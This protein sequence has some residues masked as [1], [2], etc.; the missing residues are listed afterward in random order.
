[1]KSKGCLLKGVMIGA[2]RRDA[3]PVFRYSG[4]TM[5]MF[6]PE[7]R[8]ADPTENGQ[9]E[10]LGRAKRVEN[11]S[12]VRAIEK[13]SGR[14]YGG[15]AENVDLRKSR[16][17]IDQDTYRYSSLASVSSAYRASASEKRDCGR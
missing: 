2:R 15:N 8:D 4:N 3:G 17:V 6:R 14:C 5:L 10:T 12:P 7:S 9:I 1:M 16:N 13:K 11:H